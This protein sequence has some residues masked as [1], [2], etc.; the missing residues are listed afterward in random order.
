MKVWLAYKPHNVHHDVR[1]RLNDA[2]LNAIKYPSD[3][4]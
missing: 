4:G 3:D 1:E 2:L